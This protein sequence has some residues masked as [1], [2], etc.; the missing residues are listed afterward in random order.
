ME[1]KANTWKAYHEKTKERPPRESLRK[2]LE[3]VTKRGKALD[4]GA[5]ALA[6]SK[7]LLTAGFENVI[8][9]DS[10][11]SILERAKEIKDKRLEI[12]ISTFEDFNFVPNDCDLINAQFSLPFAHPESFTNVFGKL[13]D[14]LTTR[15][16][17]AGQLFGDRDE[18]KTNPNMTFH[19]Q[20]EVQGLLSGLEVLELREEEKDGATVSGDSKH[21]HVFHI[22]ARK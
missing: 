9:V 2:A 18:W 13:K 20:E 12:V 19:T 6:D 15:G 5:G 8:A 21:W 17:F 14:S 7:H 1:G 4:L 22:L 10:E 11:A 16:V 3:L